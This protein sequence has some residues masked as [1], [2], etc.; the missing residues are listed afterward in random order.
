MGTPENNFHWAM[1]ETIHGSRMQRVLYGGIA[2]VRNGYNNGMISIM[3][4]HP[5]INIGKGN[6]I[7]ILVDED[8]ITYD[9]N[10]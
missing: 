6:G 7:P 10:S 5:G 4:A 1:F 8:E 3:P 2:C 9:E